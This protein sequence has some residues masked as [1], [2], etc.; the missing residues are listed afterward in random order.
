MVTYLLYEKSTTFYKLYY[1]TI[2]Y[3]QLL[4]A[5]ILSYLKYLYRHVFKQLIGL[6]CAYF[7]LAFKY[8]PFEFLRRSM[9]KGKCIK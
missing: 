2:S 6:V 1:M 8:Y 3:L 5:P 4:Y 9:Q 7:H